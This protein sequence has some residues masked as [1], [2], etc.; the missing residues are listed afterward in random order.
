MCSQTLTPPVRSR[1]SG[2]RLPGRTA[3]LINGIELN[4]LHPDRGV[5]VTPSPTGRIH[6]GVKAV[7]GRVTEVK[8][9]EREGRVRQVADATHVRARTSLSRRSL[10]DLERV[11]PVRRAG[12]GRG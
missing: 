9:G 2:F 4:G 5:T 1:R 3:D 10:L 12:A 11:A 6:G 7:P 8:H